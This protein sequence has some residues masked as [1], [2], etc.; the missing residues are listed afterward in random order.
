MMADGF[1][2]ELNGR[3]ILEATGIANL[4]VETQVYKAEHGLAALDA[5]VLILDQVIPHLLDLEGEIGL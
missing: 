2:V 3:Y 1:S 4:E 5:C